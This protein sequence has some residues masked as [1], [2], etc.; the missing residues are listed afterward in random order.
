ML[1]FKALKLKVGLE[2]H[3][4]LDTKYKLFCKCPTTIRKDNPDYLFQRRLRPTPSELGEVD[5]AA[6][7]EFKRGRYY[8]YQSYDDSV[9]LVEHDEEPPHDLNPE[10]VEIAL[11]IA[12]MLHATPVDEIQVMRK[13]VIDGSNT[14]GFQRTAIVALGGYIDVEGKR[15]PIQTICLEEDAARKISESEKE[16]IYR[17]DR[18]GIPLIEIATAPVINTPEETELVAYKIGQLLRMTG[19]VKRGLGT[20]R[21]DLNISIE[22]GAKIEIKGV[23]RLDLLAKIVY[24]EVLRQVN[25]LKIRDELIKREVREEDFDKEFYNVTDIFQNTKCRVIRRELEKGGVVLALKL[26]KFSGLLKYEIQPGRRFGT[27]LADYAKFWGG[28]KGLFHTD[29]LPAYGISADEVEALRRRVHA[30]LKDAVVIIADVKSKVE[31]ALKAVLERAM[32][33]LKGVPEETRGA[34]PD[35]TTHYSRPRPGSARMY[36]ETD[37]RPFRIT[38]ELIEKVKKQLPEPPEVKFKKFVEEYGLSPQ[39]AKQI[40]KSYYLDLFERFVKRFR[41]VS[42]TLIASTLEQT[43]K[44]IKHEGYPID[45]ISDEHFEQIFEALE[46]NRISKEAIP[47]ILR[48]FAKKPDKGIEDAIKDLGL[49]KISVEEARKII[50][51]II[52]RNRERILKRR[53]KALT[54]VMSNAMKI[55]KGKIDA[56]EVVKIAKEELRKTLGIEV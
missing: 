35:G 1:D 32:Y 39:L 42:P 30:S 38:V 28:V 19:K 10:A 46:Q 40:L 48:Y 31:D 52:E 41:K 49:T 5:P 7:F 53:N 2:L 14:T 24:Y 23:Q 25:L 6:L 20:I 29:E 15:V 36:P 45:N 9:C 50:L 43:L 4:Q 55:L 22:K 11:E 51:E 27:E 8:V 33:A 17:L 18:L 44:M 26:P 12:L 16:V 54:I 37:I 3:Q 56:K 13:I 21:Q 34:N 47:D